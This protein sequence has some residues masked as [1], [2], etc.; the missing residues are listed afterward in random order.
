M[1]LLIRRAIYI[2]LF[3][4]NICVDS[5][6]R[7][8]N[9]I[10]GLTNCIGEVFAVHKL[11]LSQLIL[12]APAIALIAACDGFSENSATIV[13]LITVTKSGLV[14][15]HQIWLL[16]LTEGSSA[17]HVLSLVALLLIFFKNM[18]LVPYQDCSNLGGIL[19]VLIVCDSNRGYC[20]LIGLVCECWGLISH[21]CSGATR[22]VTHVGVLL[23]I[24]HVVVAWISTIKSAHVVL[25]VL[26]NFV[27]AKALSILISQFEFSLIVAVL[28]HV[29][30]YLLCLA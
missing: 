27:H 28:S 5:L 19:T 17:I 7:I 21:A 3:Y 10:H 14:L 18:L 8:L 20:M 11:R 30:P 12:A 1:L 29:F 6:G 25:M 15:L 26:I 2:S 22:S 4:G 23:T 13:I 16:L 24:H 9:Y